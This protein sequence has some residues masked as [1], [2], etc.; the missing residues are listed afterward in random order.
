M[1]WAVQIQRRKGLPGSSF[2][3]QG[4]TMEKGKVPN[5]LGAG[6]AW[7]SRALGSVLWE[8]KR[9]LLFPLSFSSLRDPPH[10]CLTMSR[11]LI[12]E[13]TILHSDVSLQFLPIHFLPRQIHQVNFLCCTYCLISFP[14]THSSFYL[15]PH[16]FTQAPRR[17]SP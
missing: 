10:Q 7:Q 9:T 5:I 15:Y 1:H 4:A 14:P 8:W 13:K 2:W 12:L 11:S 17:R 16:C 3:S 6:S